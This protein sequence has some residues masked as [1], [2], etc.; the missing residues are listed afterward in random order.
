MHF[1][2][3]HSTQRWVYQHVFQSCKFLVEL[4]SKYLECFTQTAAYSVNRR[5]KNE[6][7]FTMKTP[8]LCYFTIQLSILAFLSYIHFQCNSVRKWGRVLTA[9]IQS[10]CSVVRLCRA[11]TWMILGLSLKSRVCWTPA[12]CSSQLMGMWSRW[13]KSQW[14]KWIREPGPTIRAPPCWFRSPWK[15]KA[16]LVMAL[17]MLF[18]WPV[19]RPDFT[20]GLRWPDSVNLA[21]LF[22]PSFW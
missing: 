15:S 10:Q 2:H 9:H 17:H 14:K 3:P 8:P 5:R 18:I 19:N 16:G 11:Y 22:I 21:S 20:C 7:H 6:F 12:S 4:L 13:F 1:Y